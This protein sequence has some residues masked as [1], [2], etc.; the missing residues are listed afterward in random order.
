MNFRISST[1]LVNL[2]TIS[3]KSGKKFLIQNAVHLFFIQ[4]RLAIYLNPKIV[5]EY[6]SI[7]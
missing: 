4:K 6:Y 5:Q 1:I 3:Q 7:R 2:K